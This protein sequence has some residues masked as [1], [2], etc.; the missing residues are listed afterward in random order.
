MCSAP[1]VS[2]VTN[3][4]DGQIHSEMWKTKRRGGEEEERVQLTVERVPRKH[5]LIKCPN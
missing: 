3:T 4:V 5:P 2:E 1:R